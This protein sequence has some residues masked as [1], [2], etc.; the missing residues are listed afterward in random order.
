[1]CLTDSSKCSWRLILAGEAAGISIRETALWCSAASAVTTLACTIVAG[2]IALASRAAG[3]GP[4]SSIGIFFAS[5]RHDAGSVCTTHA[6]S[7]CQ[8]T[9]VAILADGVAGGGGGLAGESASGAGISLAC[10]TISSVTCGATGAAVGLGVQV[11]QV[12]QDK[13]GQGCMSEGST[14]DMVADIVT[15]DAK[16]I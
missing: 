5:G 10:L 7:A 14:G 8:V 9:F 13:G 3:A 15:A 1:M 16:V 2:L 12:Q 6:R 4:S 11:L